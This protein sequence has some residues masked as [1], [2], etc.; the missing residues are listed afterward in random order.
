VKG[1]DTSWRH[2]LES[3]THREREQ[4][5]TFAQG[6][7]SKGEGLSSRDQLSPKEKEATTATAVGS[8]VHIE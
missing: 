2:L 1:E 3:V 6:D 7:L 8:I 5:R 4:R